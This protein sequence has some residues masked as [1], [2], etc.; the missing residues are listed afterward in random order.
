MS[1]STFT[2]GHHRSATRVGN[3]QMFCIDDTHVRSLKYSLLLANDSIKTTC[4]AADGMESIFELKVENPIV[5][6]VRER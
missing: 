2:P 3:N 6:N 1:Q 5:F 4:N